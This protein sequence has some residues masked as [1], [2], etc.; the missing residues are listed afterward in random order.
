[1]NNRE[2]SVSL[3][4]EHRLP[5]SGTKIIQHRRPEALRGT[6]FDHGPYLAVESYGPVEVA[7]FVSIRRTPRMSMNSCPYLRSM[8]VGS[9]AAGEVLR[10]LLLIGKNKPQFRRMPRYGF[11]FRYAAF[12]NF[13][14]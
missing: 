5:V 3:K 10:P 9:S 12:A 11:R 6:V 14:C 1:M 2:D 13:L 7:Q 8:T 4:A